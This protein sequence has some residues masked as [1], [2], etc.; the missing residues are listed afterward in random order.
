MAAKKSVT[1][2]KSSP[3]ANPKTTREVTWTNQPIISQENPLINNLSLGSCNDWCKKIFDIIKSFIICESSSVVK[4]FKTTYNTMGLD[5]VSRANKMLKKQKDNSYSELVAFR[6]KILSGTLPTREKL[7]E[8]RP[9]L[10]PNEIC[11][12]CSHHKE[13]IRHTFECPKAE[14][15]TTKIIQLINDILQPSNNNRPIQNIWQVVE[16][17]CGI[18]NNIFSPANIK[19]W[20]KASNSALKLIYNS[21]WKPRCSTANTSPNSGI[22]WKNNMLVQN[23]KRKNKTSPSNQNNPKSTSSPSNSSSHNSNETIELSSLVTNIFI[24]NDFSYKKC[25]SELVQSNMSLLTPI[26]E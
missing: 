24:K 13:N 7:H 22:K 15:S 6:I 25:I 4:V 1:I 20:I 8:I 11:P 21:I 16:L 2:K 23:P 3:A 26:S 12:R 10:Y 9:D 14:E 17:A 5:I 19:S 18:T